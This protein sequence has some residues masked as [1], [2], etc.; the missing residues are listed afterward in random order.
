M[1]SYDF[2]FSEGLPYLLNIATPKKLFIYLQQCIDWHIQHIRLNV[3]SERL[4]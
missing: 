3:L 2:L 1:G 4:V